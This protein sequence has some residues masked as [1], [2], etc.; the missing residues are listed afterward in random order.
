MQDKQKMTAPSTEDRQ[1][2]CTACPGSK[3]HRRKQHQ[4]R[5][6]GQDGPKAKFEPCSRHA[7]CRWCQIREGK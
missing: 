1:W 4:Y 2:H 3:F 5:V 6:H 7:D